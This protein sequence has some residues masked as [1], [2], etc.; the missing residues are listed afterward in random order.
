MCCL[1]RGGTQQ[2]REHSGGRSCD[3]VTRSKS[4]I[5]LESDPMLLLLKQSLPGHYCRSPIQ[6]IF[7][8]FLTPFVSWS[9]TVFIRRTNLSALVCSFHRKA[10]IHPWRKDKDLLVNH[11]LSSL[12]SPK[13]GILLDEKMEEGHFPL[14]TQC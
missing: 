11:S 1:V 13:L 4:D 7:S 2:L 3:G 5:K 12:C 14:W 9:V 8:L 10:L 6:R